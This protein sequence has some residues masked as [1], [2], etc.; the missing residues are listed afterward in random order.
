MRSS[1]L[2]I[3]KKEYP[4]YSARSSYIDWNVEDGITDFLPAMTSNITL[5]DGSRTLIIN[6]RYYDTPCKHTLCLIA[7][8][9]FLVT[10][11]KFSL[12]LKTRIGM[13]AEM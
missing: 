1:Y 5:T 11:I 10:F 9:L 2:A 13:G 8:R 3:S 12:M 6:A 7:N 4:H